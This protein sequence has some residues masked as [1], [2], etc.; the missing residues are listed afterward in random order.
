MLRKLFYAF[1]FLLLGTFLA[2]LLMDHRTEWRGYQAE[3][4]RKT[5]AALENRSSQAKDPEEARR[6]RAQARRLRRQPL[7]IRQIIAKDLGRA[8]RCVTCHAGMDEFINP[9]MLTECPDQPF[10]GHPD[11]PGLVKSHPFQK[12]GCTACHGGQGLATT[13]RAAH[14][15]AENWEKPLLRGP[16]LQSS[17]AKCH[18]DFETLKGAETVALGKKLFDAHGCIGCHAVRGAGGV[19]SVDLGGIADKPLERMAPYNFSLI[20][21]EDGRP[22]PREQWKLPAW[23]EAHLTNAPMDFIPNDPYARYNQEPIAPSGMPDF[24]GEISRSGAKAIV[25]YLLSMSEEELIPS[26]YWRPPG[27]KAGPRR[28]SA[29]DRG[30]RVF[31]KYGCA[32][33]HGLEGKEGR[34]NYNAMGPGQSDTARDMDK[35]REPTLSDTVGTFT[36]EELRA[37]VEDGVPLSAIAKFNPAGPTPPLYMPPWKDRIKGAELDDLITYLLSIAKKDD[38]W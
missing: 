31:E 32:G 29:A 8:D 4:F 27:P 24:S 37:K 34:R 28:A 14:G 10:S 15:D 22:L 20:K 33:C 17:C 6:L 3:Y 19:I 7:Q 16:L 36:R 30:K 12:F 23:I 25:A 26:R 11:V 5:A 9:T 2:A 1:N 18:G 35:G 13:V 21:G 38:G